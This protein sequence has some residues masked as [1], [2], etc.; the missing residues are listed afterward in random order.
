MLPGRLAE[1][2]RQG[3]GSVAAWQIHIADWAT[4]LALGSFE[5]AGVK[6]PVPNWPHKQKHSG[7]Q[8]YLRQACGSPG[9]YWL[10]WVSLV[11]VS[12]LSLSL[13]SCVEVCNYRHSDFTIQQNHKLF[14]RL[15]C[16]NFAWTGGIN[17]P[18]TVAEMINPSY[19]WWKGRAPT[20]KETVLC[21]W[22]NRVRGHLLYLF[23]PCVVSIQTLLGLG[24]VFLLITKEL[25]TLKFKR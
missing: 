1:F 4:S 13:Q 21:L 12:P 25:Q 19:K 23:F 22:Q 10:Q 6:N 15:T 8:G 17:K 5:P 16:E 11:V 20:A 9:Y 24:T 3:M 18:V 14:W 7:R 2:W